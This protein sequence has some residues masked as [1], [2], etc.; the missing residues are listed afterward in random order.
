MLADPLPCAEL[1][2]S[3]ADDQGIQMRCLSREA[4]QYLA[5]PAT[6]PPTPVMRV[7][8]GS[9]ERVLEVRRKDGGC[10]TCLDVLETISS[11]FRGMD[12]DSSVKRSTTTEEK[13]SQE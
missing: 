10:V 2:L 11:R 12:D 3:E 6:H 4:V 13:V 5:D 1:E 9:S 7:V 8:V